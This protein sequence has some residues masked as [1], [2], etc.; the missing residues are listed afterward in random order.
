VRAISP[1]GSD[2]TSGS[3]LRTLSG[4]E[5]IVWG[6]CL[7]AHASL[8]AVIS[9]SDDGSIREWDSA[10]GRCVRQY[11]QKGA[12]SP[13]YAVL[14]LEGRD[15]DLAIAWSG[16]PPASIVT[17]PVTSSYSIPSA[18]ST[19]LPLAVP[20][21][22]ERSLLQQQQPMADS[23]MGIADGARMMVTVGADKTVTLWDYPRA[24]PLRQLLGHK[25][26]IACVTIPEDPEWG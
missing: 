10:T 24:Q 1:S 18:T 21:P 22:V 20:V 17:S 8:L 9:V 13:I 14:L 23:S 3:C 2:I 19:T 16:Q 5:G 7:A 26:S 4:H 11:N 25:D 15:K 12:L 6:A